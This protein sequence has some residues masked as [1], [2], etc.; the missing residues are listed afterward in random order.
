[1]PAIHTPD[2]KLP[3]VSGSC[4]R[5]VVER[6]REPSAARFWP[7]QVFADPD[8]PYAAAMQTFVA[9]S[10]ARD[11]RQAD[12]PGTA[13]A[14]TTRERLRQLRLESA[15]LQTQ[16]RTVR[17][18]RR[19]QDNAWRAIQTQHEQ[20]VYDQR[21]AVIRDYAAYR[22]QELEWCQL[23]QQRQ[24]TLA[25]RQYEDATW[26]QER[27]R[28]RQALADMPIVTDWRAVLIVTDNCTRQCYGL[29]LFASGSHV[30]AEQVVGQLR[31]VLPPEVQ[32][33]ISDRGTHF[34]AHAFAQFAHH[35][36][37]IHVPIA[38]HRPESNGIAERCVRTLKEWLL[39]Y[40]WQEDDELE[41]LLQQFCAKYNDRPHQGI[42]IPG[43]SPN[44]F[45]HRIWLF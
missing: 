42:A 6:L 1:V 21:L 39:A 7:G 25:R 20:T 13:S 16:R 31:M 23:K 33:V 36:G 41:E 45:A 5:L 34:T 8:Q 30:T 3:A 26:R 2:Q 38:R 10:S 27:M 12:L 40:A 9:A 19:Q 37:F 29:P 44:E 14:P 35:A 4:G 17:E 22:A 28:L 18:Q 43:L 15:A 11:Q 32:F 24:D